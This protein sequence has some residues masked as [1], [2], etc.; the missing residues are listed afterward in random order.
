MAQRKKVLNDGVFY[1]MKG[2][3]DTQNQQG[4]ARHQSWPLTA[5]NF[6]CL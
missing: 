5:A 2:Q 3:I 4:A 1:K 6:R